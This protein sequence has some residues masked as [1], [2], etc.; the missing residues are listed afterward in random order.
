M[1]HARRGRLRTH[2]GPRRACL[3]LLAVAAAGVACVPGDATDEA[4]VQIRDSAGVRIVEYA[5]KPEVEAPFILAAEPLYRHGAD[6]GDYEFEQVNFGRLFPDGGAILSDEWSSE[7]VVL[8]P[9][10]TA[11]QVLAR[12]G[13]GPGEVGFVDALFAPG[14]DSILVADRRL[15][16]VTLFVGGSI[17]RAT[18]LHRSI[19]LAV[20]GID[21]SGELL[22][23]TSVLFT[24]PNFRTGFEGEWRPGHM[25][26]VPNGSET[27]PVGKAGRRHLMIAPA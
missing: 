25:A 7:L 10:G 5:G 2:R 19:G 9:D 14:Q 16:R 3:P 8:S 11:H 18:A 22:L 27:S 4:R 23:S 6:P 15:G 21:A 12:R 13:E 26:R 17:A 1:R 20:A 24:A